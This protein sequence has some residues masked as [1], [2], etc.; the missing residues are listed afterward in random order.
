MKEIVFVIGGCRSGKSSYAMQT[1]EKV[2][3]EQKIFIATCVPQDDEMKRR[4]ARHQKERSQNWVTVEAPLDLPEAILQNSRRGDVILIDCL[5]LWVSNLLIETGDEKKIEDTIPQ[6]IEALQKATCPIVLV[7]NEVGTGIVPEN[8][9]AR[10]FRD[11]TGW[12]NQAVARCANKVVWMVAG[13]P[14]TVK[15]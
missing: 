11:I 5:T 14:V 1:A 13:I 10:Q 2:P 8:Q 3:A 15:G 6:L 9:L 12:V 7:S 4:V